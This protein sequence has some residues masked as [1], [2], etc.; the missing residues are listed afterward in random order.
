MSEAGSECQIRSGE[1]AGHHPWLLPFLGSYSVH[2]TTLALDNP[3]TALLPCLCPCPSLPLLCLPCSVILLPLPSYPNLA[4]SV[5][6]SAMLCPTRN[7]ICPL[8]LSPV[9]LL[10]LIFYPASN[11][12]IVPSTLHSLPVSISLPPYIT[13]PTH[14]VTY[15]H[16]L[17]P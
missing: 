11:H 6:L 2:F 12:L 10:P 5:T 13:P 3:F 16:T 4:H 14:P 9:P 1:C 15:L 7:F 8:L 17:P